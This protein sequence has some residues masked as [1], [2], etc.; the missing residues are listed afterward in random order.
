MYNRVVFLNKLYKFFFPSGAPLITSYIPVLFM[1][2]TEKM[3]FMERVGNWITAHMMIFLYQFTSQPATDRLLRRRF[4][5]DIPSVSE[6][7]KK[8]SLVFVNQHYSMSL[9]KPLPPTIIELGGIHIGRPKPLE[10]ELQ[11]LLNSAEH[12]VIY[13][14]WGIDVVVKVYP[15]FLKNN[16]LFLGSMIKAHTLPDEKREAIVHTLSKFKQ[17]VLWKWENETIPNKPSNVYIRK[18]MPQREILCNLPN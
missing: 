16:Y 4:G 8:T 18:W 6:L 5:N 7:V 14:S 2:Y 9:P 11:T 17:L 10:P 13:I 15:N 1:E 3:N 12:G